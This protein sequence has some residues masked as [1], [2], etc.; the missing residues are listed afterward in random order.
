MDDLP[1][2]I[3]NQN[4][5]TRKPQFVHADWGSAL[6]RIRPGTPAINLRLEGD[7]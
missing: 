6:D 2:S 1:R 3:A 7:N 4:R 5:I